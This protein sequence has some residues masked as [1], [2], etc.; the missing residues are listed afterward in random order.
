MPR[1]VYERKPRNPNRIDVA[2]NDFVQEVEASDSDQV[3]ALKADVLALKAENDRLK[4]IV[5]DQTKL[6]S[7]AVNTLVR[8]SL[9]IG[10]NVLRSQ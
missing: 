3:L 2:V 7:E 8:L 10:R 9:D 6:V 4:E 1:G 5:I